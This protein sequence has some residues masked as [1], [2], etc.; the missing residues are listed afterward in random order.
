MYRAHVVRPRDANTLDRLVWTG[1]QP[2]RQGLVWVVEGSSELWY[3]YVDLA[4]ARRELGRVRLEMRRLEGNVDRLEA[5]EAENRALETI[6]QLTQQAPAQAPVA[7][8]VVSAGFAAS[9]RTVDV[10]RGSVHD[11]RRGR[12]VVSGAGLAGLVQRSGWTTSEVV[13]LVDPRSTVL[14]RLARSRLVGRVRGTEGG[15]GLVMEDVSRDGDVR[16]GD[17]VVTSGLGRIFP[18]DLPIGR[19]IE[20]AV[21]G[22]RRVLTL[23]PAVDFE[24]LDWVTIL[25]SQS[26]E[27]P[28]PTPPL[29][30]PPS[31]WFAPTSGTSPSTASTAEAETEGDPSPAD[32][33]TGADPGDGQGG[34]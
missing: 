8:R 17:L 21:E 4:D 6:L 2:V 16:P 34:G 12:A 5:L 1:T 13:L 25:P 33:S 24:R 29:L 27:L 32:A 18:P 9:A 20:V 26:V 7:A 14:A 23:A 11:V 31:L 30:R 10:D 19:V 15:T 3:R 22:R 28:G